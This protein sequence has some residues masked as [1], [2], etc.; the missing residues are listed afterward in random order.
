MKMAPFTTSSDHDIYS[1]APTEFR[2]AEL[3][4]IEIFLSENGVF[5]SYIIMNFNE[6]LS[7]DNRIIFKGNYCLHCSVD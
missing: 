5:R 6:F 4:G 7:V 2:V 3:P 1:N